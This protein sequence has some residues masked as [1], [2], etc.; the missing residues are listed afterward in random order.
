MYTKFNTNTNFEKVLG[1][2]TQCVTV[3]RLKKKEDFKK[4]EIH[5]LLIIYGKK[6]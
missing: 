5:Y 2:L 3:N 4:Y 6:K 1:V